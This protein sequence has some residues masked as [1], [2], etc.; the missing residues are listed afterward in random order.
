MAGRSAVAAKSLKEATT[1]SEASKKGTKLNKKTEQILTGGEKG[2]ESTKSDEK[3]SKIET[4]T[5][6]KKKKRSNRVKRVI[7]DFHRDFHRGDEGVQPLITPEKVV[8]VEIN[9]KTKKAEDSKVPGVEVTNDD[10][11]KKVKQDIDVP[12]AEE[13]HNDESSVSGVEELSAKKTSGR[14]RKRGKGKG[15]A[16]PL[17]DE[18]APNVPGGSTAEVESLKLTVEKLTAERDLMKQACATL[19][20]IIRDADTVDVEQSRLREELSMHL[21]PVQS[22]L[23][24][25][26]DM[27]LIATHGILIEGIEKLLNGQS[28]F[29]KNKAGA[30]TAPPDQMQATAVGDRQEIKGRKSNKLG[31]RPLGLGV[32]GL[33]SSDDGN[34]DS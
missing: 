33:T 20:D 26:V 18:G 7:G 16:T 19:I 22:I 8:H 14:K 27:H 21:Q 3:S 9:P 24:R 23:K 12:H 1:K 29:E 15:I 11:S 28:H 13:A 25:T 6:L 31:K 10:R 34:D 2:A 5:P 4:G 32:P 17:P 30:M